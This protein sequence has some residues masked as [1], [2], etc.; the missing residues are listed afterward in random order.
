MGLWRVLCENSI[1]YQCTITETGLCGFVSVDS[2]VFIK[3]HPPIFRTHVLG[4]GC[5]PVMV[6]RPWEYNHVM[7]LLP[8][9]CVVWWLADE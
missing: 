2:V 8:R 3:E 4:V 7:I 1:A 9:P 5:V 6:G